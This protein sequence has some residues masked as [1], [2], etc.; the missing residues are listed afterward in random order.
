MKKSL[1][2][3]CGLFL[4]SCSDSPEEIRCTEDALFERMVV[5][6]TMIYLPCFDSWAIRLDET[7][8]DDGK[9]FGASYDIPEEYKEEGL[10]V[11]LSA[12][13]H[14]FDM[15]LILPDPAPWGL[16]YV[17]KNFQISEE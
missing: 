1:I 16:L 9:M 13:F 15:E 7:A 8:V 10:R 3:F 14:N 5:G 6:G 11:T 2:L 17:I 12:C 4:F